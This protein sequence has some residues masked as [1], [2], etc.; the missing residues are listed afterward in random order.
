MST[1]HTTK[2][3]QCVR[4]GGCGCCCT[5]SMLRKCCV[6][7]HRNKYKERRTTVYCHNFHHH[8]KY[9]PT[10]HFHRSH[11][12]H[13]FHFH[14]HFH[15]HH[16]QQ[17]RKQHHQKK[18]CSKCNKM[19]TTRK[20]NTCTCKATKYCNT[21]CQRN[22]WLEHQKQ[23]Q[24]EMKYEITKETKRWWYQE[25]ENTTCCIDTTR[26][27]KKNVRSVWTRCPWISG[28]LHACCVVEK[29]CIHRVRLI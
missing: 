4:C 19:L 8:R 29:Q 21:Q 1:R 3:P 11:H 18:M 7:K 26:Y 13:H 10:N 25:E 22:H 2:N 16:Q 12:S 23:H 24:I 5:E 15:F 27:M 20:Q 28:Q 6:S 9:F 17:Q 14:F